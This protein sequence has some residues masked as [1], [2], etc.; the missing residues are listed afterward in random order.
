MGTTELAL[1]LAV[2]LMLFSSITLLIWSLFRYPVP[3]EPAEHRRIARAVG[4]GSRQTVFEHK[5]VAPIMSLWLAVARRI[6]VPSARQF[7][8]KHLDAS[9]NP[10]GYS[11]DEYLAICLAS[12]AVLTVIYLFGGLILFD[13]FD[14]L[15]GLVVAILGLAG[16]LISLRSEAESRMRRISKQLPYTMDLIALMIQAGATFNES[17]ETLIRDDPEDDLNQ[18]L[19][20]AL[21]EIEFGAQRSTA[22][23]NM[24]ERVPLDVMRSMVGAINQ[25]ERLGTPLSE[26]LSAQA[27]MLRMHRSVRAEKLS[28][29][30]S[31]RILVPSMLILFA[32]VLVVFGPMIIRML[33][34]ELNVF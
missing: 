13:H 2:S 21:S 28:A 23:Q 11:I 25:S 6:S 29:S 15:L 19:R 4:L 32:V 34:G 5:L 3:A 14:L 30:A 7:V 22:L 20:I 1:Q 18:E 10:N 9:G 17:V 24:A 8:R 12:S 26:I 33:R 27:S 31:L 16:P